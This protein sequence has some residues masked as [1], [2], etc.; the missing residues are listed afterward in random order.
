MV[1]LVTES[2]L[3]LFVSRV[4]HP[5]LVDNDLWQVLLRDGLQDVVDNPAEANLEVIS[6][7]IIGS[8]APLDSVMKA[9]YE[10]FGNDFAQHLSIYKNEGSQNTWVCSEKSGEEG[11]EGGFHPPDSDPHGIPLNTDFNPWNRNTK[12]LKVY[13]IPRSQPT[14]A[15][16]W[17]L[18]LQNHNFKLIETIPG[19]RQPNG[20]RD[21]DFL[22]KFPNGVVP[23]IED[24]TTGVCL[25]ESN[26][27]MA[28]LCTQYKWCKLYP[29]DDL[30]ARAKVDE[31]LHWHH[32]NTRSVTTA[33]LPF[34]N[35]NLACSM[36]KDYLEVQQKM[37]IK[38]LKLLERRLDAVGTPFLAGD[39]LT[40]A[41]LCV[42]ADVGQIS[43]RWSIGP[44][45]TGLDVTFG[46]LR[47]VWRWCL[48]MENE[49][50]YDFVHEDYRMF[51]RSKKT[52]HNWQQPSHPYYL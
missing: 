3:G 35:P 2:T 22:E 29:Y 14:R 26:A 40:I 46:D 7:A 28:Y 12:N 6:C 15:I 18:K 13:G 52:Q 27:I 5:K 50:H 36:P 19:S 49:R 41:D 39:N 43:P 1:F 25:G 20:S 10:V 48:R 11:D 47:C 24:E 23:T 9:F 34:L 31:I 51:V 30:P 17:L 42:Y 8:P 21:P 4:L 45:L 32:T 38:S 16:L 33:I 44:D 37:A